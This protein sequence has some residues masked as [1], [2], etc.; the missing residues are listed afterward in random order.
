MLH[1]QKKTVSLPFFKHSHNTKKT[2]EN[3]INQFIKL[4]KGNQNKHKTL[5]ERCWTRHRGRGGG[6]GLIGPPQRA[7]ALSYSLALTS[8]IVAK[9]HYHLA[10]VGRIIIGNKFI[11]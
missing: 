2:I 5:E 3:K 11:I 9:V 1:K 7:R 4:I 8:G 6:G 10:F